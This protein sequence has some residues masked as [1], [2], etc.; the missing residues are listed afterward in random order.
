MVCL[1]VLNFER[2]LYVPLTESLQASLQFPLLVSL[3]AFV[4]DACSFLYVFRFSST[5]DDSVGFDVTG[6]LS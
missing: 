1:Q 2:L 5:L 6:C 4:F 3:Y